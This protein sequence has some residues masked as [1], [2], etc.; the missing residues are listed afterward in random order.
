L[1]R[2]ELMAELL[3]DVP[4]ALWTMDRIEELRSTEAPTLARVVIAVD[5][6]GSG[7]QE[8]DECGI[9]AA[10]V[11]H[12]DLGWVLVARRQTDSCSSKRGIR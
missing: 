11:D 4:G 6:S 12:D 8:A 10:G 2:Q 5:P 3:L 7:N 9:V 1:G